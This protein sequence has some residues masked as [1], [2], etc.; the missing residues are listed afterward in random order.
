MGIL[1]ALVPLS[2]GSFAQ[3]SGPSQ[4]VQTGVAAHGQ[5][6]YA[7]AIDAWE[8]ALDAYPPTALAERALVHEN[9]ARTHQQIGNSTAALDAWVAAAD[10]YHQANDPVQYG[11]S[12]SEQAQVYL[13]LGRPQRA[14]ALLCGDEVMPQASDT[15]AICPG[16]SYAIATAEEDR[17]GQVVALGSLG[18]AYRLSDDPTQAAA[19][20]HQG[21]TLAQ[22]P[23]L[24]PYQGELHR[25]L[26]HT[27][28]RQAAVALRRAEAA[29]L[30][31]ITDANGNAADT[32]RQE[33]AQA[34]TQ[35]HAQLTQ[36][37]THARRQ[38]DTLG[39]LRVTLS[40]LALPTAPALVESGIPESE[41]T[42]PIPPI[43]TVA[44]RD[45]LGT[46]IPQLPPSRET[47][48][49]A[50]TLARVYWGDTGFSCAVAP[51]AAVQPWLKTAH[52]IADTIGDE[53]A[54]AFAL[55]EQGHVAECSG[56]LDQ[57]LT[58][59]QQAQVTAS[60][61]LTTADSLYLWQWQLG[62]VQRQRGDLAAA[63]DAY[64]QAIATL[65]T[66]RDDLLG[67]NRELQFDFR[68]R[69]EPIYRQYIDLQLNTLTESE[70]ATRSKQ[71]ATTNTVP[72]TKVNPVLDTIDALR[73]A[74]LQ[75][76]FGNDCV[77]VSDQ[78]AREQLL[79]ASDRTTLITSVVLADQI[80]ILA[81][82]P[83]GQSQVFTL[84]DLQEFE[85]TALEYRRRLKRYVVRTYDQTAAQTLYNQLIAPLEPAL[86]DTDT[87]VFVH[88]G[89]LRNLPMA[90][91]H[92]GEQYLIQRFAIAT[93]PSLSLTAPAVAPGPRRALALGLSDAAVLP[94]GQTFPALRSVPQELAAVAE[95]LPGSTVLL[96]QDFTLT[97]L[98][99]ALAAEAFPIVH[100]ATHGQ[101]ST[102]P[103]QTFVVTGP[104]A[105]GTATT[106]TFGQLETLL[107]EATPGNGLLDLITLTA[108]ETAT[109]DN[110]STLGLA[111]LAIRAGARSA[112]A[113]L[114]KVDDATATRL[115]EQFYGALNTPGRSKAAA[116]RQAQVTLIEDNP[117]ANP[118]TWAPL[119]LVGN[120]Q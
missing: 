36:A 10:L 43:D 75:N 12:L 29:A 33:A 5:A 22:T 6:Q 107:R 48:Y 41:V 1:L 95:Q 68:D 63:E 30:L 24:A 89:L 47:A 61:G 74:E 97:Q 45:R 13:S 65:E 98:Q 19:L 78:G 106:L 82:F 60:N 32:Q 57:A 66:I 2:L 56:Q 72:A 113:S 77:L 54:L 94:S 102:V 46:L 103:E 15:Q 20:L 64:D 86:G 69:V 39:E 18:E 93:T 108:C 21:L 119:I 92:D 99:Q 3:T 120:W 91:L 71:G 17:L 110:R 62:R 109:G 88:D 116:L 76:F 58:L 11:R 44:L 53:R 16:G 55:G 90:A 28:A 37:H 73:L 101:F 9:I 115:I 26:G 7:A 104:D 105:N 85:A 111:G 59:T 23:E 31:N 50:L 4:L 27:Y 49:A 84:P 118:G 34:L 114:W 25:S 52:D 81:R 67:A 40:L 79:G 35:A 83:N 70:V 14:K 42:D 87:L 117:G 38:G 8:Q 96:N 112:I 80:V 51:T 100:L